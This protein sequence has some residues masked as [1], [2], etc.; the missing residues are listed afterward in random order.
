MFNKVTN[1]HRR[2]KREFFHCFFPLVSVHLSDIDRQGNYIWKYAVYTVEKQIITYAR[3]FEVNPH[4]I[5]SHSMLRNK[6][7]AVRQLRNLGCC[8]RHGWHV[9][10][11]GK[12][13]WKSSLIVECQALN[14]PTTAGSSERVDK[15]QPFWS[16]V[17]KF[18]DIYLFLKKC[19]PELH[20][21]SAP[22]PRCI[23]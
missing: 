11:C 22:E 13:L 2:K 4:A 19:K 21:P 12:W 8:P 14:F 9:F 23:V 7:P 16:R 5:T 17:R 15:T 3:S 20:S 1:D 6:T 10:R 18:T